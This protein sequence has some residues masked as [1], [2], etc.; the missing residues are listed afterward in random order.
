MK[1]E[2]EEDDDDD[3]DEGKKKEQTRTF[4]ALF[5]E[6]YIIRDLLQIKSPRLLLAGIFLVGAVA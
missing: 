3:E 1:E 2:E 4:H 5:D 6:Q